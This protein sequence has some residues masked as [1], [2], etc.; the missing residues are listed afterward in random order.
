MAWAPKQIALHERT[1]TEV[2]PIAHAPK[3]ARFW[4]ESP[5]QNC[6]RTPSKEGSWRSVLS[7]EQIP[8]VVVFS[9][10]SSEKGERKDRAFV[11]PR[12][13]RYQAALRPDFSMTYTLFTACLESKAGTLFLQVEVAVCRHSKAASYQPD[14][15]HEPHG[16]RSKRQTLV[17]F[18]LISLL[19]P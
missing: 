7:E 13:V 1:Q 11:R 9:R 15:I 18:A 17:H 2:K 3:A 12:Q 10:K 5:V 6:V 19:V 4:F 16:S 8:Q 14:L